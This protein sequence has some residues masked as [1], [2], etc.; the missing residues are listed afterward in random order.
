MKKLLFVS[1]LGG[2]LVLPPNWTAPPVVPLATVPN[3]IQPVPQVAIIPAA[4]VVGVGVL[5]IGGVA[6]QAV[7]HILNI[8]EKKV[9]N[10]PPPEVRFTF[11]EDEYPE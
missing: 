2:G 7:D 3:T 6:I 5:I 11:A 4:I 9:T 1:V 8:W 10:G